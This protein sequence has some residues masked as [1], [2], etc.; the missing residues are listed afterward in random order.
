M[1]G[2]SA[3]GGGFQ[4]E[5]G[6]PTA[7]S[8]I[9]HARESAGLHIA[10]LAVA[11][12]VPVRKL[13]AL[14][15]DRYDLLP[16]AVFARALASSV[17]RT[18]K[19]DPSTVLSLLPQNNAARA[20]QTSASMNV[21]FRGAQERSGPSLM[22]QMSRPAVIGGLV[23]LLAAL[24]LIFMPAVTKNTDSSPVDPVTGAPATTG[25]S[26]TESVT[27]APPENAGSTGNGNNSGVSA[28]APATGS[29]AQG[30]AG[31][32][33][34]ASGSLSPASPAAGASSPAVAVAAVPAASAAVPAND[35]V[36][37]KATA[38]SWIEV[39]DARRVVVL[40]RTL[41][42]GESVGATGALPL[43]A[44]VGRADV[45]EVQVRGKPMDL[46]AVSRDNVARFEVR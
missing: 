34:S 36:V 18:L 20:V 42:A 37:F 26:S 12:K 39:T 45:T 41:N 15:A 38:T 4:R 35:V 22:A 46:T 9:R 44:V 11:L 13:E 40:R 28:T 27:V 3:S 31:M 2:S 32:A 29:S 19:I 16:D 25:A 5:S 7:G 14:E 30:S 43:A 8:I 21:P 17:C 1:S 33:L 23:L 10:A 24:V 6:Q